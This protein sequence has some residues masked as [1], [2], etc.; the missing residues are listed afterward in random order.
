MLTQARWHTRTHTY[1]Y[2]YCTYLMYTHTCQTQVCVCAWTILA[3]N[4]VVDRGIYCSNVLMLSTCILHS[5]GC[6]SFS[7]VF[8]LIQIVHLF[9]RSMQCNSAHL[10]IYLFYFR[11][12][13]SSLT[14]VTSVLQY[15]KKIVW[16]FFPY[17][18]PFFPQ[19]LWTKF[20]ISL[21][22]FL[23]KNLE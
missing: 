11:G 18:K 17:T 6:W 22:R 10:F 9:I 12:N 1:S 16:Y 21:Y 7:F 13:R 20:V 15:G 14:V 5:G 4:R 23:Q 3:N 2:M 8:G 19:Y